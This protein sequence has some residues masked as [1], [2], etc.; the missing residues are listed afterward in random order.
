MQMLEEYAH[1]EARGYDTEIKIVSDEYWP[2]NWYLRNY[3]RAAFWGKI[4]E[5]S[6][7][8]IVI[9]RAK[10][11]KQLEKQLKDTYCSEIFSLRPG[12]DLI[13]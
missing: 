9:G 7:A 1:Q 5:D 8:S 10:N 13:L 4:L 3:G 11:Q 2:L 12:L 6:D